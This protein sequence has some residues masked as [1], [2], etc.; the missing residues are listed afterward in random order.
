[1]KMLV[2]HSFHIGEQHLRQGKPCQDYALSG[3]LEN[4]VAYAIV[5]DGCS[6]GGMTDF[7]ARLL[8]L[9]TLRSIEEYTS[10]GQFEPERFAAARDAY[11]ESYRATLHLEHRDLLATSLYAIANEEWVHISITG[12][13]VIALQHEHGLLIR[14]FDW[15]NN[16]PYYPAYRLAGL[17]NQFASSFAA[18]SES[19]T[20]RVTLLKNG[21]PEPEESIIHHST[22]VG[23]QGRQYQIDLTHES[24]G[25]LLSIA[26]FSDGVEQI[27]KVTP[28]QA[29]VE[30]MAFKSFGGQFAVRRM[31]RYLQEVRK[32]GL[33][34]LDDIAY[35]VIH[36]N[37][38]LEA[39]H[40]KDQ[41][42]H[43][44][45]P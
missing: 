25:K 17:N 29:V 36:L 37:H 6:S 31:N 8:S 22:S 3:Q 40:A 32:Q 11:L 21:A 41:S 45:N 38:E 15:L 1:M 19:F 13:G 28:N 20:E 2:D 7:G 33:S 35:A 23:L 14:S 44:S 34:P 10:S 30:L 16:T 26:L 5:S 42:S 24:L 4:Q 9:A 43:E 39:S 18:Q 27:E 12:D